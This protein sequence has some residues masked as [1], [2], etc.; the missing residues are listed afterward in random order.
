MFMVC[1][2]VY[3]STTNMTPGMSPSDIE[4]H[5]SK[6]YLRYNSF[7]I[8]FYPFFVHSTFL[9]LLIIIILPFLSFFLP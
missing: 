7:P 9:L 1:L 3:R 4:P 8:N 2:A 5:K 6:S